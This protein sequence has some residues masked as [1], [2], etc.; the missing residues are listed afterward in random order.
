MQFFDQSVDI[1]SANN[2]MITWFETTTCVNSALY[3]VPAINTSPAKVKRAVYLDKCPSK[4][5]N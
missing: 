3:T 4:P 5:K 2:A 1:R